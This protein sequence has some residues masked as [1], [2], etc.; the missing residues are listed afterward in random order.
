MSVKKHAQT[1]KLKSKNQIN[2]QY[3]KSLKKI[4]SFCHANTTFAA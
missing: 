4:V 1:E 2:A 3:V